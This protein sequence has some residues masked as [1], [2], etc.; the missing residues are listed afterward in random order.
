M[1]RIY[2]PDLTWCS[3]FGVHEPLFEFVTFS[4]SSRDFDVIKKVLFLCVVRWKMVNRKGRLK[5]FTSIQSQG[6]G[7]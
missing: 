5:A 3:V 4:G 1:T 6:K 7:R 2:S